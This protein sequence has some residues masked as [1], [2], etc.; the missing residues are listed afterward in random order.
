MTPPLLVVDAKRC[1]DQA[2]LE[3][4][5]LWGGRERLL[6]RQEL[7]T[8]AI[9]VCLVHGGT[10]NAKD[11]K[12]ALR[13]HRKSPFDLCVVFTGQTAETNVGP[14]GRGAHGDGV[15]HVTRRD[16]VDHLQAF[17]DDFE[18]TG[19]PDAWAFT[20]RTAPDAPPPPALPSR[21][22]AVQLVLGPAGPGEVEATL[23][24]DGAIDRHDTLETLAALPPDVLVR[25][26][27]TYNAGSPDDG[28]RLFERLRLGAWWGAAARR[29]VVLDTT[30]PPTPTP[31][32]QAL[33]TLGFALV[34]E[35]TPP[36][37]DA[38][39]YRAALSALRLPMPYRGTSHDRANAWGAL[40]LT[41]GVHALRGKPLDTWFWMA[42]QVLDDPYYSL[43]L[44]RLWLRDDW[45]GP[46]P[47][48]PWDRW[49]R[50]VAGRHPTVLAVDDEMRSAG[51]GAALAETFDAPGADL[52]LLDFIAGDAPP[53]A[54]ASAARA[55][56]DPTVSLLLSDLRM[57]PADQSSGEAPGA[58]AVR[59]LSGASLIAA[60]KVGTDTA[61]PA[62][63]TLPVVVLTASNKS[64]TYRHLV[65]LG[66]DAYWVKEDPGAGPSHDR[67]VEATAV[68][69]A[70]VER[71]LV[72]NDSRTFLWA[73]RDRV[74]ALA[75][76]P[77]RRA[78]F[79]TLPGRTDRDVVERLRAVVGLV[80]QAYGYL[81]V[82]ETA[83]R[84]ASFG[85]DPVD[86]A[87]LSLWACINEILYLRYSESDDRERAFH[88]L[89]PYRTVVQY[90][91]DAQWHDTY[92]ASPAVRSQVHTSRQRYLEPN[93]DEQGLETQHIEILLELSP[94][95][96]SYDWETNP[97]T[98]WDRFLQCRQLRNR[99]ALEHGDIDTRRSA[100]LADLET[101]VG[102]WSWTLFDP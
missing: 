49:R 53:A 91:S 66:A 89:D 39:A 90:W 29:P 10:E 101:L 34:G 92:G 70:E 85:Q 23:T 68:L 69:L 28:L 13:R 80:Q 25:L 102:I 79:S 77:E 75:D 4:S 54:V 19:T 81:S 2:R 100:T 98:R 40:R 56:Q 32:H 73:F 55:A 26:L 47:A 64:W 93:R 35:P 99:L 61:P 36:P 96:R 21:T 45:S 31:G 51:W 14:D 46:A 83:H 30:A 82:P 94:A 74:T 87:F 65:D 72:E 63:P 11:A 33:Y 59:S 71:V 50:F 17:L 95:Q 9:R 88:L 22:D 52:R 16:L 24:E 76:D 15:V 8:P 1:W 67:T 86:V 18:R 37:V 62:R 60:L 27:P 48:A 58:A 38:D 6:A 78:V 3:A 42:G 44:S 41:Y 5:A 57:A 12:W 97:R 20:G 43:L 7:D 84:R